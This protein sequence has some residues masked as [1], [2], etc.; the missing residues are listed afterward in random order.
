[1]LVDC[2][3]RRRGLVA[4]VVRGGS[5]AVGSGRAESSGARRCRPRLDLVLLLAVEE[6]QLRES[7]RVALN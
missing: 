6:R 1:M 7:V 3:T 4:A 2:G 5:R